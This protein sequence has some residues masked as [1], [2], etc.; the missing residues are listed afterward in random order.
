MRLFIAILP[1]ET[2]KQ[3]LIRLQEEMTARKI[4]GHL[5]DEE[6]LHLTLAFIGEYE[7]AEKAAAVMR[8][9]PF[10]PFVLV[11]DGYGA[12]SDLLFCGISDD[13]ELAGYVKRL[14]SALAANG[15][16]YDRKRFRPHITLMR[17]ASRG[18]EALAGI[19]V[20]GCRMICGKVSLMK[21]ERTK[22]G[23]VYTE[24]AAAYAGD[25]DIDLY[26]EDDPATEMLTG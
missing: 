8:S 10:E 22:H 20:P 1:D 7:D 14:R 23:M 18:A 25:E 24:I 9:V 21:S 11:P 4:S 12:F 13:G 17:R 2:M 6:S 19:A 5:T 3:A 15:I 16:P 26:E